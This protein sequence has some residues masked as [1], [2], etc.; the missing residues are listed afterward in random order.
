[1]GHTTLYDEKEKCIQRYGGETLRKQTT[2]KT[3]A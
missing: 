2:W 3:W 1:V